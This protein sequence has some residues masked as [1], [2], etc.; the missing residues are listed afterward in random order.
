MSRHIPASMRWA[1][2]QLARRWIQR[3]LCGPYRVGGLK[4]VL[5]EARMRSSVS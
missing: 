1:G 5:E 4:R 2:S 3:S